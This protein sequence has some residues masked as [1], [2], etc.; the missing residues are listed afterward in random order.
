MKSFIL[1]LAIVAAATPAV[2]GPCTQRLADL[3]KTIGARNEGGGP[4]IEGNPAVSG[5]TGSGA[6]AP[7]TQRR[8]MDL[9]AALNEAK[10]LDR[11]GMEDE[12]QKRAADIAA[13]LPPGSR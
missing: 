9:M 11:A 4:A 12:C 3:E 10:G 7:A 2:A 8:D 13:S 6:A 1:V 5:S